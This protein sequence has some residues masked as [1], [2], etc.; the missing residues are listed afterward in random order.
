MKKKKGRKEVKDTIKRLVKYF[1]L[2]T[3]AN[4]LVKKMNVTFLTLISMP[5][6]ILFDFGIHIIELYNEKVSNHFDTS[7]F[8]IYVT[9]FYTGQIN[10]KLNNPHSEDM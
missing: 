3:I 10:Y 2:V 1:L 5:K 4:S 6:D 8:I 7:F 9:N